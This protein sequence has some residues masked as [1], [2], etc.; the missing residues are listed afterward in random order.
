MDQLHLQRPLLLDDLGQR[1]RPQ[2]LQ[3]PP[4]RPDHALPDQR[5]PARPPRQVPLRQGPRHGLALEP[6]LAADGAGRRG[7]PGRP[8]LRIYPGR[9]RCRG[10][11][12]LGRVPRPP[13]RRPRG[14]ERAPGQHKRA[15]AP[16]GPHGLCRARPRPRPGRPHQP[17]RRPALQP[18]PFRSP[19]QQPLCHQNLLG[20]RDARHPAAGK[21]GMGPVGLLHRERARRLLRDQARAI[22]RPLPQRVQPPGLGAAAPRLPGHGFRERRR[23]PA[24]GSR[25]RARPGARPH[26]FAGCHT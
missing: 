4:A 13:R 25:P 18:G 17:V 26:F 16:V 1:R 19:S 23:R 10:H 9:S 5:R 14:L 8:R 3:E 24:D 22:H 15:A 12:L 20:H 2:L 6:D 7:L 11:R 21:Q